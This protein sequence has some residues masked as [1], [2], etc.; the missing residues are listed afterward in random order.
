MWGALCA[1]ALAVLAGV[2]LWPLGAS[3]VASFSREGRWT[4]A[5]YDRGQ[6]F[7]PA[8]GWRP[9]GNT[10]ANGHPVSYRFT[11]PWNHA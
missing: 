4:L 2:F 10:R 1:P 11:F 9:D 3:V 7:Y 5:N 6:R 8:T